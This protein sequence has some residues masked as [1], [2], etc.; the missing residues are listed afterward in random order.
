[1]AVENGGTLAC[2]V[3]PANVPKVTGHRGLVTKVHIP[4]VPQ[5]VQKTVASSKVQGYSGCVLAPENTGRLQ[6]G[7]KKSVTACSRFQATMELATYHP[8]CWTASV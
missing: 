6:C 7:W 1:M 2:G 8:A 5:F 3:C 4:G